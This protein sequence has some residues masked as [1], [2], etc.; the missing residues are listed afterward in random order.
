MERTPD[1]SEGTRPGSA[2]GSFAPP[3]PRPFPPWRDW[4]LL[5]QLG[6][7]STGGRQRDC[8]TN[9]VKGRTP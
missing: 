9:A 7:A 1:A 4:P 6:V 3:E 5:P 8:V 2:R